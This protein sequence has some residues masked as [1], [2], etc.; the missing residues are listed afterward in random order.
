MWIADAHCHFFSEGF[1]RTLGREAGSEG[2]LTQTLPTRLGWDAPGP[3]EGLADRWVGELERHGV[4]RAVLIASAPGDEMSVAAAVARHPDRLVGAFM[5]HPASPDAPARLAAGL[6]APG[7]RM[8]CLFP[9]MS[10]VPM[11]H[12]AVEHVFGAAEAAQAAV[13]V[14]CG[15]LSMGVRRK[16]GLPSRFDLR[17]G[18]PLAVAAMAL[19]HPTVP[20]VIPHFGAGLF[21]EALMAADAAANILM[22]TSSSNSWMRYHPGLTL[23]EVFGRAMDV[24]GPARLLFGTDASFFP[25]GWLPAVFDVQLEALAALGV[26]DADK[27]AVFGGNFTRVFAPRP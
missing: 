1:F 2:D 5:H 13:F 26:S 15:V 16:L 18:D 27:A 9:A 7:M 20:V 19:R 22:D 17:L 21:R 24:A 23:R 12:P 4:S 11:D 3:V 10:H 14:H 25:R 6:A 8:V